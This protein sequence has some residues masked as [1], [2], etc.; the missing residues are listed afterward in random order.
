MAL[1]ETPGIIER[2][3]YTVPTNYTTGQDFGLDLEAAV[4]AAQASIV[5]F[6]YPGQ[7]LE[8]PMVTR[9]KPKGELFRCW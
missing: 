5:R 7:A 4:A 9:G 1:Y 8:I 3:W 6:E 2:V